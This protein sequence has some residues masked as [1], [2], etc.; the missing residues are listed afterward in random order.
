MK[1]IATFILLVIFSTGALAVAW[2]TPTPT[3][4]WSDGAIANND[5]KELYDGVIITTYFT[6]GVYRDINGGDSPPYNYTFDLGSNKC[7]AA[8]E[9]DGGNGNFQ[10][11]DVAKA[12]YIEYGTDNETWTNVSGM[13]IKAKAAVD[14]GDWE[15]FTYNFTSDHTDNLTYGNATSA[16]YWRVQVRSAWD[17]NNFGQTEMRWLEDTT[18]DSCGGGTSAP[19][20]TDAKC[21]YCNPVDSTVPYTT[22]DTT[23][24]FNITTNINTWCRIADINDT[25]AVMGS[26]KNCTSGA[27]A[28]NHTCSLTVQDELVNSTDY[29][30]VACSTS[31]GSAGSNASIKLVMDITNLE[32]NTSSAIDKGIQTSNIWPATAYSGQQVYIRD[33]N[34]NQVLGTVDRVA[35]SGSQ[36]WLLNYVVD[37]GSLLGLFN[38]TPA[39][40]AWER[41]DIPISLIPGSISGLINATDS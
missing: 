8:F 6:S 41:N 17:S 22:Y 30:Y 34:N 5:C 16:R 25:F 15:N 19:N 37:G 33:V 18:G 32:S 12:I 40:Y 29:V 28:T 9:L 10:M 11:D 35:V 38:I 24:T 4:C 20:I 2:N 1:P 36:R 7:I 39:V 3:H 14:T 31:Y 27:G 13:A 21:T 26:A 23:P